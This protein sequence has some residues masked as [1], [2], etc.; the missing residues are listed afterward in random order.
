MLKITLLATAIA[1][2]VTP[3]FAQE[4]KMT[5]G[6]GDAVLIGPDGILHKRT[7]KVLDAEHT[8]ALAKGA[9]EISRGTAFYRRGGKLYSVSCVGPYIGDWKHGYPGTDNMC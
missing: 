9:N 2:L 8:G 3:V 6:E 7:T 5:L 4:S 1:L